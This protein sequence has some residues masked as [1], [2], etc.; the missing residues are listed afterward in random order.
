MNRQEHLDWCKKRAMEYVEMGDTTQA[1]A[2]FM[3]D[4]GKHEETANHL[5]LEMGTMLLFG[6]HLSTE[7][8][9]GQWIKGFN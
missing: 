4:M 5:A 9:M 8:E 2:S 6:G 3:S 7:R 1:F